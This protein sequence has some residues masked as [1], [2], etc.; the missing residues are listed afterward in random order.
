MI[1]LSAKLIDNG[2]KIIVILLNDDTDLLNQNL[3]R[4]RESGINPTP[5]NYTEILEEHIGNRLWIIFC[6]KNAKDLIKLNNALDRIA[7]KIVIDDEGDYA[8]PNG[9]VNKADMTK[10]NELINMLITNNGTYIGVTATPARLDLNNTFQNLTEKWVNFKPHDNYVGKEVFFPVDGNAVL[11]FS[12]KKLP[13]IGDKPEYIRKAIASFIVN[14]SLLN[15]IEN[16]CGNY[17][18]LI[19]TSGEV[20]EHSK[21]KRDTVNYF[22]ALIDKQ[23]KSHKKY[24]EEILDI[25]KCNTLD[26]S[27]ITMVFK[28]A[29]EN[30]S[31][32][33]ISIINSKNKSNV[34]V[35]TSEPSSIYSIFIGGNK[36]SRGITFGNLI[37]M[38]FTRDAQKIQ[39]DTYIQRARMFGNRKKFL[40]YFEL[41][42]TES[43]YNDWRRCFMYHYLSL[44]SIE[45]NGNA[46]VWIG[47]DRIKPVAAQSIDKRTLLL[48]KGEMVF[49]KFPYNN[50]IEQLLK[51]KEKLTSL[52]S[53]LELLGCDAFPRYVF[54]FICTNSKNINVDLTIFPTRFVSDSTDYHKDL[55]RKKG[56]MGGTDLKSQGIHKLMIVYNSDNEA[57]LVYYF[58][59]KTSFFSNSRGR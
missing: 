43:L 57:R 6:K 55:Y 19:H 53:L 28:F 20:D 59:G 16:L 58:N 34:G 3:Q 22:D 32:Q 25:I 39:Q 46:P 40:K 44:M 11:Q 30:I 2:K 50:S 24:W 9:K 33:S 12:L 49:A 21:D 45:T 36:V 41:W 29:Y 47:D 31:N 54:D 1:A 48:D 8:S 5:L 17:A 37:G 52:N 35:N 26:D 38:F 42:I 56:I 27:Q 51:N 13:E 18:F 14:A 15:T 4:F 7:D 10:I 23:N